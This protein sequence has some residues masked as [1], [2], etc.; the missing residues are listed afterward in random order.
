MGTE[1]GDVSDDT[2]TFDSFW[3][4]QLQVLIFAS[5]DIVL[6]LRLNVLKKF[7]DV[8][9]GRILRFGKNREHSNK[10][11]DI[12]QLKVDKRVV[13]ICIDK[14]DLPFIYR[15]NQLLSK[16]DAQLKRLLI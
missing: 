6:E 13:K 8:I 5:V 2:V 9:C 16:A 12:V 3:L 14:T 10:V 4:V 11:Y 1:L 15:L 7:W